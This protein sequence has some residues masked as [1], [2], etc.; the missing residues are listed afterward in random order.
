V[1]AIKI[2]GDKSTAGFDSSFEIDSQI[3]RFSTVSLFCIKITKEIS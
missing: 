1:G 2:T 3:K